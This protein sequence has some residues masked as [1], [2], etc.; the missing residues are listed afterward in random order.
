MLNTLYNAALQE[1]R[2]AYRM[3]G[4]SVSL[5]EQNTQ[6]TVIRSEQP[7]WAALDVNVARGVLRRLDR[8][9]NAFFRRVKAGQKPGFPRFRPVSR[10]QCIEPAQPRPGMVKVS[11]GGRKARIC[12]KG[13]PSIELRLKRPLPGSKALKSLR[14]VK[15]PNGWYADLVYEAGKKPL[16][17][18]SGA[19]GIDMGVNNRMA[20]STGEMVERREV[21]RTRE[22]RFR[23][24]VSRRRKGSNR[25][26]KAVRTLARETRRNA[27]RNRNECHKVTTEIVRRFGRIAV[28]K[29][30]IANM[31]RSAGGTVEQPG[32]NVAA[33]SGLNREIL[34]NTWGLLRNQL[35]YKAE[36]A[37][38][39]FAEVNPR[40]TSRECSQC[41]Q[42]TPQSEYR[43]YACGVCGHVADRDTNAAVNV[44]LRAFGPTGAGMPLRPLRGENRSVSDL[45]YSRI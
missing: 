25:R 30:A 6:L 19:V 10:F 8:A 21:D 11:P 24:A 26:R 40:Y 42:T 27:V 45:G 29:L 20:L 16:P 14:L 32:K 12:I 23:Q 39:E 3:Q 43:T 37:G 18:C 15:R 36:W 35:A 38:R 17:E 22:A 33:K 9:M 31:T 1:R 4:Q 5:Y 2:D 13:L 34:A 41:G 44:L 28:E 7:E